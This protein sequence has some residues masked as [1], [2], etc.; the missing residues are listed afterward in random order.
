MSINDFIMYIMAAGVILGGVD[1]LLGNRLGFG[2]KFED[3]FML[4]GTSALSMAGII[5]LAPPLASFLG[6]IISPV[7]RLIGADP[8]MFASILALDMGGYPLAME[9]ADNPLIGAYSGIIVASILGCTM[10]FVIPVGLSMIQKGDHAYF[11]KGL[12]IGLATM[13]VGTILGGMT[14][15]INVLTILRNNVPILL[16]SMLLILGLYKIP[17][18]MVSGFVVFGTIIKK[19]TIFG[20]MVS[21]FTSLTKITLIPGMGVLED[22]MKTVVSICIV[23]LGSLPAAY[24]LQKLLERPFAW[25]GAKIGVNGTSITGILISLV[26]TLPVFVMI[27]DMNPKGKVVCVAFLVASGAVFGAHLAFAAG[28]QPNLVPALIVAKLS[29]SITAILVSLLYIRK[30]I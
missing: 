2:Q 16:L 1:H 15:G 27:K 14:A 17:E 10:V 7:F 26:S 23:L 28:T 29:A 30:D 12:M 3:G 18:H 9:L 5:C 11:A 25:I 8:S 22:A 13:P 4:L 24:L 19:I 6:P 21:A 20:L